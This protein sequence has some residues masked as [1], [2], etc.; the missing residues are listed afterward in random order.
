[1]KGLAWW[2][3]GL[4]VLVVVLVLL[5]VSRSDYD[6]LQADFEALEQ[7]NS[8]LSSQLQQVQ[9]DLS[10]LQSDYDDVSQELED[11]QRVFPPRDFSSVT[12][13]ENW[14]LTNDVSETPF[15]TT[16]EE[17]YAKALQIQED[18]LKDGYIISVDFDYDIEQDAILVYCVTI[19]DGNIWYWDPETDEIFQYFG[20][21]SVR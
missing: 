2:L 3:L 8:G 5:F 18:A 7:Q 19:V 20:M 16:Y 10:Q 14:L 12:E 21:G 17:W 15:A 11:I 1:M 6:T 4:V 9:S 13:L